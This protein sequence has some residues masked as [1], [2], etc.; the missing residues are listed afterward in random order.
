MISQHVPVD[1]TIVEHLGHRVCICRICSN[2]GHISSGQ[3]C[4]SQTDPL[5]FKGLYF[6]NSFFCA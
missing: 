3:S 6:S 4:F 1:F 5:R 2:E